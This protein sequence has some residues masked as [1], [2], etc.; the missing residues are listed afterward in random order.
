[1]FN[2]TS[3]IAIFDIDLLQI[4]DADGI[5]YRCLTVFC[6]IAK[7]VKIFA[8]ASNAIDHET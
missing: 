1:M 7:F 2:G 5:F 4:I 6:I 8:S 3:Y